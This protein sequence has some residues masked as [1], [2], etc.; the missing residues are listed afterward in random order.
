MNGREKRRHPRVAVPPPAGPPP[1]TAIRNVSLGG[2]FIATATPLPVG[3]PIR[4]ELRSGDGAS[5][6]P[7][8]GRVVRT[9]LPLADE[10]EAPGMGI[11][12]DDLEPARLEQLAAVVAAWGSAQP[13]PALAPVPD[14]A[15]RVAELEAKV[16]ELQAALDREREGRRAAEARL[17][18][19]TAHT[20]RATGTHEPART[21]GT[22]GHA[23][24]PHRSTRTTTT[25]A[26]RLSTTALRPVSSIADPEPL[27]ERDVAD[28]LAAGQRL[29]RTRKFAAWSPVGQRE[30]LMASWLEKA[31]DYESLCRLA[32][33]QLSAE[34]VGKM[35]ADLVRRGLID[36]A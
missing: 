23:T 12:F 20:H 30:V 15:A 32:K 16:A 29:E 4:I 25:T 22:H 35:L 34:P 36:F 19:A 27:D 6:V 3:S 26:A 2:L 24:H 17:A 11:L 13:A 9:V 10:S 33:G 8:S 31:E 1:P 14:S 21:T 18:E 5:K 28:L 7:L